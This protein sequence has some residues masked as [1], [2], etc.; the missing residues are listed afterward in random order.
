[1]PH[2]QLCFYRAQGASPPATLAHSYTPLYSW[3]SPCIYKKGMSMAFLRHVHG[4]NGHATTGKRH[5]RMGTT[6]TSG[7]RQSKRDMVE[8]SS[9]T[10]PQGR[11]LSPSLSLALS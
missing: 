8:A 2:R 9:G 11:T 1:M 3:A 6:E 10:S 5:R 4:D 7:G